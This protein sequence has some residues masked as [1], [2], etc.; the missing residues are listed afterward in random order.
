[1]DLSIVVI[2]VG[3]ASQSFDPRNTPQKSNKIH[4]AIIIPGPCIIPT[5]ATAIAN[6]TAIFLPQSGSYTACLSLINA[7]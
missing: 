3:L 2:V 7:S 1:M 5:I 4:I 6:A